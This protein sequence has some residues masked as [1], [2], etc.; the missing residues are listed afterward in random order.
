VHSFDAPFVFF[1][2]M[3]HVQK[4][5]VLPNRELNKEFLHFRDVFVVGRPR[6]FSATI[7][8]MCIER[9]FLKP[10]NTLRTELQFRG[11]NASAKRVFLSVFPT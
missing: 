8:Q 6:R 9:Y 3:V 10:A 7:N 2:G 4:V 5:W 11:L 1:I